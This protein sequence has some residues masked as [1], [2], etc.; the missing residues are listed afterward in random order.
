MCVQVQVHIHTGVCT[1]TCK[2]RGK[3]LLPLKNLSSLLLTTTISFT[4]K[5]FHSDI[6]LAYETRLAVCLP[7]CG[8]K[9]E[10][11]HTCFFL[12]NALLS[13]PKSLLR[14]H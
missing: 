1:Y 6:G 9:I 4:D 7:I 10:C 2:A 12:I 8:N 13:F 11:H 5:I 14:G 3:Q